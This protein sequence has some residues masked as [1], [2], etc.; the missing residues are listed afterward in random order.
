MKYRVGNWS[1][2]NR[3]LKDRGN[4][5]IWVSEG[6]I[7]SW[8]ATHPENLRGR[9]NSYS[10]QAILCA[11]IIKIVFGLA[12]RQTEGFLRSLFA[13]MGVDLPVPDYTRICRRKR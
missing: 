9:P 10:N 5:T 1:E 6:A 2:Y 13:L 3:N 12:Y 4:L 11:M 7:D 8:M